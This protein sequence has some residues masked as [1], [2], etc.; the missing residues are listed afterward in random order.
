MIE[1]KDMQA[2]GNYDSPA[3]SPFLRAIFNVQS[4]M[5]SRG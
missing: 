3:K 2:H 1:L 4:S 5:L